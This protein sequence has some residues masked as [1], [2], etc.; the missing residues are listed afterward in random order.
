MEWIILIAALACGIAAVFLVRWFR[1][2]S[3]LP[4]TPS[5]DLC[6]DPAFIHCTWGLYQMGDM[7]PTVPMHEADL[8]QPHAAKL[9]DCVKG[10]VN[11]GMMHWANRK[12]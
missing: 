10:A 4:L 12:P 11:A 7:P 9:W 6:R 1:K 2:R 8:C 5:C 3:R